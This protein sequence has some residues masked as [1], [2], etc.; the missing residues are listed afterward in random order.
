MKYL[1]ILI[2]IFLILLLVGCSTK[3]EY[4][5]DLQDGKPH[6][7]GTI[8]YENGDSYEG[9]WKDDVMAG[10]GTYTWPN[11][12]KYEGEWKN[13]KKHGEGTIFYQ[14]GSKVVGEFRDDN[15]W[16]TTLYD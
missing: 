7:K 16:D 10:Q 13:G 1:L 9:E 11:R 3:V 12:N 4:A 2:H 14:D 15:P 5:G 8:T 6:G